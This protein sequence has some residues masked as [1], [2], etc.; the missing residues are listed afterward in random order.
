MI[1]EYFNNL[2]NIKNDGLYNHLQY[3]NDHF[4]MFCSVMMEEL[5][6]KSKINDENN[7]ALFGR[8]ILPKGGEI[9]WKRISPRN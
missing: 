5:F 4:N 8:T 7:K 3:L 6:T 2:E 1:F 9:T